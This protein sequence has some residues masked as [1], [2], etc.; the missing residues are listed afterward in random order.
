MVS[1]DRRHS[2][3]AKLRAQI[4]H[5]Q[6][7]SQRLQS[8]VEQIKV[9]TV[10]SARHGMVIDLPCQTLGNHLL[11]AF[12]QQRVAIDAIQLQIKGASFTSPLITDE[13]RAALMG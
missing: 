13:E 11:P 10:T 8:L 9:A 12:Q 4:D 5:I 2:K 6:Q 1:A 3:N 7:I